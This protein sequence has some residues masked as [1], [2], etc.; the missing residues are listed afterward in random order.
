M[1]TGAPLL[2]TALIL[3]PSLLSAHPARADPPPFGIGDWVV[4]GS[5]ALENRTLLLDG[6]LTVESGGSLTISN[7]TL[8][9][10]CEFAEEHGIRV[11]PGGSLRVIEGSVVSSFDE[12]R[13]FT[14]VIERG[15]AAELRNSTFIACGALRAGIELQSDRVV[16]AGCTFTGSHCGITVAAPAAISSSR[17]INNYLGAYVIRSSAT[18]MCCSFEQNGYAVFS[19]RASGE[20]GFCTTLSSCNLVNNSVGVWSLN[21]SCL[22][23]SSA[24]VGS[25]AVAVY[26]EADIYFGPSNI[27]LE[28]C[29]FEGNGIG[30]AHS[31]DFGN[32]NLTII[33][34]DFLNSTRFGIDWFNRP[35]RD[36][37]L[38]NSTRWMVSRES[39][40]V[41][42][43]LRLHGNV[44][45]EAGG[46]LSLEGSRL[47]L[48]CRMPGEDGI[49]VLP[50]GRLELRG[51]SGIRAWNTSF[52]HRL[53]CHPGS[54]FTMSGSLLR[55][56]GWNI[57]DP[58]ASGPLLETSD[59]AILS[60]TVDFC[61]AALVLKSSRGGPV[62]GSRL[63][64]LNTSLVLNASSL[65][66]RNSTLETAGG[67]TA[68]LNGASLLECLNSTL[69]RT[70]LEFL[71]G[72]S[73]VN[74][75]W[76]LDVQALWTDGRFLPGAD[77]VVRDA[78]GGEVARER[79]GPDGWVRGLVLREAS[80]TADGM[81]LFTP[82]DVNCSLG[83]LYNETEIEMTSSRSLVLA[84]SDRT[85]PLVCITHPATGS[86]LSSGLVRLEGA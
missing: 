67:L 14:F 76:Y 21:S 72:T 40:V 33:N 59:F 50:G 56:C 79:T 86:F 48:E 8:I 19:D 83:N 62:E 29:V 37:C 10:Y 24:F 71:D 2:L 81:E 11:M 60:S 17:F 52:P 18:F 43:E 6:N 65:L 23:S 80:I 4:T 26:A 7:S 28:D 15:A 38:P 20:L 34:C 35:Y 31:P 78:R 66:I 63:R 51:G 45:I 69:D 75:S 82:H 1:R 27:T 13:P 84:L 3:L 73:R 16:V 39:R 36:P 74:I 53:R 68:S 9:L 58:G 55:D 44:T 85:A 49:D 22:I 30:I 5:E 25:I 57:S 70:G 54:A 32:H 61:P 42:S 77:V 64:G 41:N 12:L 47:S 46:C